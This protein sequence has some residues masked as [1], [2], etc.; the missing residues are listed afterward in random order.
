[1][2]LTKSISL[3]LVVIVIG[4]HGVYSAWMGYT[5]FHL[6]S[7]GFT[8]ISFIAIISLLLEKAWSRYLVYFISILMVVNWVWGV[9]LISFNGWPY[10]STAKSIISLIPGLCLITAFIFSSFAVWKHFEKNKSK[11]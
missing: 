2:T 8:I 1:M 6:I 10:D 3:W 7:I 9:A 4:L 5:Y 11:S